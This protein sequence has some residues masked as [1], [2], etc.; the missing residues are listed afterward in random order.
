MWTTA[1][2]SRMLIA[3]FVNGMI[4]IP[5]RRC[6]ELSILT[7]GV[8]YSKRGSKAGNHL[9]AADRTADGIARLSRV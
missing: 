3:A 6:G 5:A 8:G 4:G 7:K 2:V 9:G 1:T